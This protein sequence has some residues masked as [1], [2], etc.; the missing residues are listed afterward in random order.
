MLE[1]GVSVEVRSPHRRFPIF[2]A[3]EPTRAA[4]GNTWE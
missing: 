1:Q 3:G 4:A 2:V